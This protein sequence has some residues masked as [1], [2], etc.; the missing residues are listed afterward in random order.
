MENNT[1]QSPREIRIGILRSRITEGWVIYGGYLDR[2]LRENPIAQSVLTVIRALEI[3]YYNLLF[4]GDEAA[5]AFIAENTDA[6]GKP[7]LPVP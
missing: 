7:V 5:R 2:G 6:E 1:E 4:T 3:E